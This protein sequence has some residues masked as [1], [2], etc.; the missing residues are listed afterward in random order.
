VKAKK[1]ALGAGFSIVGRI[2]R[3]EAIAR[4]TKAC[5]AGSGIRITFFA[6][7][8]ASVIKLEH[9]SHSQNRSDLPAAFF[10]AC[11]PVLVSFRIS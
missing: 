6:A 2:V 3:Q 9:L 11:G 4:F 1:P 8:T 5:S 10:T 7:S